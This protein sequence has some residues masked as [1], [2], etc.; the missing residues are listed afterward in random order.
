MVFIHWY[1]F[2]SNFNPSFLFSDNLA[3]VRLRICRQHPL[4]KG[5]PPLWKVFWYE[6]KLHFVMF[7]YWSVR[8]WSQPFYAITQK[9]FWTGLLV[10][11]RVPSM[12]QIDLFK[13]M[14]CLRSLLRKKLVALVLWW[15]KFSCLKG[16]IKICT[17]ALF[18]M[19]T[20]KSRIET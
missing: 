17:D 11:V 15:W 3:S 10:P 13:M 2:F 5:W 20:T 16:H 1:S 4:L 19:L 14:E 18:N 7:Q 12:G 6:T 9:S 8:E